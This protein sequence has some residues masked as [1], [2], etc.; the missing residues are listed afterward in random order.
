MKHQIT[1]PTRTK[2]CFF[3]CVI[4]TALALITPP[5][6][7]GPNSTVTK[8]MDANFSI[9]VPEDAALI[10]DFQAAC[11]EIE[12]PL[13]LEGTSIFTVV[14]SV[15]K[16][17]HNIAI[18]STVHGMATDASGNSFVFSYA[19][20]YRSSLDVTTGEYV[21][22]FDTDSFVMNGM[23]GRINVG[24][25]GEVFFDPADQPFDEKSGFQIVVF[26]DHGNVSVA[27]DPL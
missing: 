6:Q 27:C 25:V 11:P 3:A 19:N 22:D 2:V 18:H 8:T 24:F 23:P 21:L 16:G 26:H 20:N 10:P 17:L 13:S 5:L 4:A 1:Y 14:D 9:T 15:R 7:A 12:W